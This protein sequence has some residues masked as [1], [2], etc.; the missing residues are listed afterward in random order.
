MSFDYL[1]VY[2]VSSTYIILTLNLYFKKLNER[3]GGESDV[4]F[5]DFSKILFSLQDSYTCDY[6]I[7]YVENME[8]NYKSMCQYLINRFINH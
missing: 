8:F 5:G 4:H 3:R 7:S 6:V 2:H 1:I